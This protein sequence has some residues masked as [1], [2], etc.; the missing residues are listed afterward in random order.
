MTFTS[1]LAA[2]TFFGLDLSKIQARWMRFRRRISTRVLL[3]DFE[4]T[5][6][7]LAEAQFQPDAVSID[8]VRRYTLPEDALERGVPAE[9]TKM[10]A[11]IRGFCQEA[12][13]PAHRAAVV[14]SHDAVFT[15]LV[16]L[17]SSIPPGSALEYL[18]DP[19]SAVQLP[20]QLDQMEAEVV[21]LS[22]AGDNRRY[23]I[24]AVP[25]KLIDR[26]LDTLQ[27][28]DLEVVRLQVGLFAQLQHL[29]G[30]LKS[31]NPDE[32]FLH[33]EML[34]DCTQATVLSN[35][36]PV[37]LTRLPAIRDFPEPTEEPEAGN[38]LN[39]E[40]QIISSDAYHPLAD[41]DLRSLTQELRRF[42]NQSTNLYPGMQ[43]KGVA[44][45]GVNSAHPMLASLL[46]EALGLPVHVNRPLATQGVGQLRPEA[47][48]V[49]QSLGRLVGLALSMV[50]IT[51]PSELSE[52]QPQVAHLQ[53]PLVPTSSQAAEIEQV[54]VVVEEVEPSPSPALQSMEEADLVLSPSEEEA[55]IVLPQ[56][57]PSAADVSSFSFAAPEAQV[58]SEKPGGEESAPEEK[59][60]APIPE[61]EEVPFSLGD[62]LSSYEARASGAQSTEDEL[63]VILQDAGENNANRNS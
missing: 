52:A 16:N 26:V 23:F 39:A 27:A 36:G 45:A 40:A 50:N 10:A 49:I 47:P 30:T 5:S 9:P 4:S 59:A 53:D 8:H 12:A 43:F 31:L 6:V 61:A 56:L 44:L 55:S 18:K 1:S 32:G 19:K 46:Q 48:I 37:R 63:P 2:N 28:A 42:I 7:T 3:I 14:L 17:P 15:T 35:L 38:A 58:P 41:V 20:I 13:I 34:R 29:T 25:S 11:L 51:D 62:L 33:L 24:T 57:N 54:A 60:G 22:V 21:P